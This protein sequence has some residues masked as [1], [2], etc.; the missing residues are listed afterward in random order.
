MSDKIFPKKPNYITSI[1]QKDKP[2]IGMI[3]L[4]PLPGAPHYKGGGLKEVFEWAVKDAEALEAGGADGFIIE[5][6]W[7]LP[8][9]KPEDIG[10]ETVASMTAVAEKLKQYTSLPIGIN[11]LA[12][13]AVQGLSVACA[14]DLPFVRVNQWVNAY[15][16]NEGFVE[17][18]SAKAMR[19]R[20]SIKGENIKLFTDVHV[21]HGSHSIVADRSLSDQTHD[22]IFFDSDVL[23]ATG[24]R[25]GSET[26]SEEILGIKD[27]TELPVIIGS[28]MDIKNAHRLLSI[29]DGCIVGSSLKKENKWWEPVSK[30]KVTLFMEEVEKAREGETVLDG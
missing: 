19:Y 4:K 12:N 6:A 16:A 11:C 9:S 28:G 10:Y 27:H 2:V 13:G 26:Q 17:G 3:H 8:F 22:A 23:I 15:I 5:N 21:K 25:T 18:A 29:A 7:D 30:D 1:F 14:A 24:T 20:S